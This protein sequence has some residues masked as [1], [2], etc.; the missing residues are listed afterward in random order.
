MVQS[1]LK[2]FQLVFNTDSLYTKEPLVKT[3]GSFGILFHIY[4]I[5]NTVFYAT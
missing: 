1:F 3:S 5:S 2:I 4:Y